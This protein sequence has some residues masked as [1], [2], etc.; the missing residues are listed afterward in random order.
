MQ[1]VVCLAFI[2]VSMEES[3]KHKLI[4]SI[5]IGLGIVSEKW[6]HMIRLQSSTSVWNTKLL[7]IK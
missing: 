1:W 7:K 5:C 6:R 3:D 2:S 4:S